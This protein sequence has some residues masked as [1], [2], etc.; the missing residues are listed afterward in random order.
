MRGLPAGVWLLGV[1]SL[2]NDV[3]SEAI[4]PLLPFFLTTILGATA[5]SL[6]VIEGA[7]EAVSSVLKVLSGR[8][9]DRWRRRKPIVIFGYAL[10]GSARPFISIAT[11]WSVVFVL[12]FI[13]RVGKG[14]RG[15]PRDALLADLADRTN[16]GK[17]YGFHRAMDH[18]GAVLG[19]LLASGFLLA[20]PESYRTLFAL[21]AIPGLAT[22]V[23]LAFLKERTADLKV[24]TTNGG[25]SDV[26]GVRDG[27]SADLQVGPMPTP[28]KRYLIALS[29]FTLGNSADAFLLLR[30]T[31][32]AGGPQLIPLFWSLLHVVKMGASLVGGSASDRFGRRPLIAAGWIV[33]AVVYAGFAL[34]TGMW[35]LLTWFF[36]YGVYYGCVEGTERALVADF[37]RSSQRGTAFGIYNAVAGI[38]ALV[39]SVV[40]GLIWTTYGSSVA[41][42]SGAALALIAAA[43]LFVLVPPP[44]DN[45]SI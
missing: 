11:G 38:G 26:G 39:S 4:Y 5:V 3:A 18:T 17:V 23:L 33:Y 37:A 44:T 21:T 7:A 32:A 45:S 15:A 24:G 36:I 35:A 9:S 30:L 41:F 8:L 25:A 40:F 43:L 6:G 27:R 22:V 20:F 34:S 31:E 29:I 28:L 19:P 13:D 12:R 16:R 2:L 14:I 42:A 10:S 1:V